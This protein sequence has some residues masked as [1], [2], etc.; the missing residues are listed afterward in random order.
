M[1]EY[2]E[3]FEQEF[4]ED[5]RS[6]KDRKTHTKLMYL[7]HHLMKEMSGIKKNLAEKETSIDMLRQTI[8]KLSSNIVDAVAMNTPGAILVQV[9][10]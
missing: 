4:E 9:D 3:E 6:F 8:I 7:I 2:I 5:A 10:Q 1:N